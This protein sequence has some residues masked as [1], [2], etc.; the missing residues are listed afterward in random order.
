[1]CEAAKKVTFTPPPEG[2][3]PCVRPPPGVRTP[4]TLGLRPRRRGADDGG[5]TPGPPTDHPATYPPPTPSARRSSSTRGRRVI[6][7]VA[8]M[9][10]PWNMTTSD[11][12]TVS[13][14]RIGERQFE[15]VNARGGRLR[16]GEGEGADF[17][18]VEL[19]LTAI[20]GCSAIDVDYLTA[21]RA[22]PDSFAAVAAAEKLSG[23]QGNHLGPVEVTFRLRF[24]DGPDGDRARDVLPTALQRSHDRLCTVSRT[25]ELPTPVTFVLD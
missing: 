3:R 23:E 21:R 7:A 24:P 10:D 16:F 25:V 20:A 11:R 4:P 12:K 2:P 22:E 1:M 14:S 5:S 19:L 9:S 8:V 6:V 17:T 18:P 15:A 13:I